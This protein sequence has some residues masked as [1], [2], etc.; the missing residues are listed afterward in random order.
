MNKENKIKAIIFDFGGVFTKGGKMDP[1]YDYLTSK[2]G[3]EAG[4]DFFAHTI[5]IWDK[6]RVG[7]ISSNLFWDFIGKHYGVGAEEIMRESFNFFESEKSVTDFVKQELKGKYKLG[8]ITN[9]IQDWFEH[10]IA[11][12]DL[13]NVF[14]EI[15]TSY[16]TGLK[17][18]D[19]EIYD[20]T[21]KKLGVLPQECIF[22]DD[23]DNNVMGAKNAGMEAIL[24]KNLL[25]L[26]RDLKKFG[27]NIY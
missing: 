6:A 3:K 23:R 14:D 24:F 10:N 11:E 13:E 20:F 27:I 7:K 1:F 22:I 21:I 9:N 26:K 16:E 4:N 12:H 5:E 8:M 19:R 17:K 18:P 2:Y 25:Q 15:V